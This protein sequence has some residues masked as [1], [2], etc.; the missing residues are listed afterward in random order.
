MKKIMESAKYNNNK[1][2][3]RWSDVWKYHCTSAVT[4]TYTYFSKLG[5]SMLKTTKD[6]K[7]EGGPSAICDPPHHKLGRLLGVV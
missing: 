6:Y 5:S 3:Y 4:A 1:A 7:Y 2:I